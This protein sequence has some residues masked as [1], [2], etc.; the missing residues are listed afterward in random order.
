M[1]ESRAGHRPE[2]GTGWSREDLLSTPQDAPHVCGLLSGGGE[3]DHGSQ[4][5][6]WICYSLS[7]LLCDARQVTSFLGHLY[8]GLVFSWGVQTSLRI[9]SSLIHPTGPN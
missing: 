3:W 7:Q 5:G 9:S 6:D 8:K 4:C 2:A 1:A